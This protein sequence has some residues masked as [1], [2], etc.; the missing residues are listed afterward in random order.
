MPDGEKV[1]FIWDQIG[2][3]GGVENF[4]YQCLNHLPRF[5]L[6][7]YVLEVG[8]ACGSLSTQF[9]PFNNRILKPP[10]QRNAL[11]YGPSILTELMGL[12]IRAIVLNSWEYSEILDLPDLR[13][14]AISIV[15]NDREVF[16]QNSYL[17]NDRIGTI[18]GVSETICRK[19]RA[20]LPDSRKS[21]V[22]CI[23]Y[24]VDPASLRP[25]WEGDRPLQLGYIGRIQQEQK[26]IF[27]LVPF[28]EALNSLRVNCALNIIGEGGSSSELFEKLNA[29]AGAIKITFLGPLLHA[30]AMNQLAKQD[31]YLLFSE[32]EGLPISLLE[33]LVRGVVPVVSQVRSGVS[34]I[35]TES[36]NAKI[37]PIGRPD[38]AA[39]M[40]AELANN[41]PQ[42]RQLSKAAKQVGDT[43]NVDNM[44]ARYAELL[45]ATITSGRSHWSSLVSPLS[46]ALKRIIQLSKQP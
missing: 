4:L 17:L 6:V 12:G 5:G 22:R 31:I 34:E 39:R 11:T 46:G 7:P 8:R 30:E 2:R 38:L 42:L 15:H 33:A 16:Y 19:L 40:V 10:H 14:P 35:L 41:A 36:I 26:R 25:A 29:K 43:F 37:F 28:V 45:R 27:D 13:I 44:C 3:V 24:G 20:A 1:L 21:I 9:N 23:P 32:F 18:V